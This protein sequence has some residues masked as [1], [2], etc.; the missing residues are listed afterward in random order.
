MEDTPNQQNLGTN[1][2]DDDEREYQ[3]FL[4]QVGGHAPLLAP[5]HTNKYII[6]PSNVK[7]LQFYEH[8]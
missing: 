2:E 5:K 8:I 4:N 6:K 3:L 7:E 1:L